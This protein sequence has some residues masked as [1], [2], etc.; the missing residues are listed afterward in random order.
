MIAPTDLALARFNGDFNCA[1]SVFAAFA[2]RFGIPEETALKLASAFGGGFAR[3]GEVCGAV[4]GALLV[5]GLASG[6]ATK[7]GKLEAYRLAQEFMQRFEAKHATVICRQLIACD[8]TTEEGRQQAAEK[9]VFTGVCTPLV[10]DAVEMA[11]AL[12]KA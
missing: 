12:L 1:Q 6:A 5:L 2:P 3:R 11:H 4:T 8:L 9:D 10:C 7:A